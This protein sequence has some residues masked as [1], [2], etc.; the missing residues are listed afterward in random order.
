MQEESKISQSKNKD[1]RII[2]I[3]EDSEIKKN[4]DIY[5]CPHC[6][7]D[8]VYGISRVVGYF[9]VIDNWN[10]SKKAELKRRQKGNYRFNEKEEE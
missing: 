10:A 5:Y 7:S 4:D 6:G 2:E 8:N 9:S 3:K 1:K